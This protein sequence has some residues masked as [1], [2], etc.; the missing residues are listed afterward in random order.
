MKKNALMFFIII[1]ST[2]LLSRLQPV[3]AAESEM[4]EYRVKAAF[5]FNFGK[6]CRWPG[7]TSGNEYPLSICVL[8]EDVFGNSFDDFIGKTIRNRT[9]IFRKIS[10]LQQIK[11]CHI[12]FISRSEESSLTAILDELKGLAIL[13]VSDINHF[14]EQG[15]MIGMVKVKNKIRFVI[16]LGKAREEGLE[17]SSNLLRLARVINNPASS[18][19]ADIKPNNTN[20]KQNK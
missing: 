13:T 3:Q 1:C 18:S 15:G 14:A 7:T 20:N 12:L 8:G 10:S 4:R 5:T 16:N 2:L 17:I 11:S 6:F 9:V 19:K